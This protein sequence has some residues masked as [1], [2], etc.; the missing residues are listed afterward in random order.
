[1]KIFDL[2]L[3]TLFPAHCIVCRAEGHFLCEDCSK[4][5]IPLSEQFC[6][7][8][9]EVSRHGATCPNCRQK[10]KLDGLVVWASYHQ[11]SVLQ[12]A[13]ADGKYLRHPETLKILGDLLMRRFLAEDLGKV[14]FVPVPLHWWRR[15]WRGFNQ[16]ERLLTSVQDKNSLQNLLKRTRYTT[17]QVQVASRAK[18]LKNMHDVFVCKTDL[19][20]RAEIF[21]IVDD[22]SSTGATLEDCARALKKAGAHEVYGLVLARG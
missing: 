19:S 3:E 16:A 5:I 10:T 9:R 2:I 12:K 13:I 20:R 1:M 11:N 18:R 15:W 4:Q 17:P 8:C 7:V 6:P 21:V 14:I 22:V